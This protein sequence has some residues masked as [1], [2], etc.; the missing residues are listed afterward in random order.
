ML[1]T[2][3]AIAAEPARV[4][5]YIPRCLGVTF[6]RYS[7]SPPE[8]AETRRVDIPVCPPNS[9]ETFRHAEITDPKSVTHPRTVCKFTGRTDGLTDLG[10]RNRSPDRHQG[11]NRQVESRRDDCQ[12]MK[13]RDKNRG[14]KGRP[15]PLAGR[16]RHEHDAQGREKREPQVRGAIKRVPRL[17]VGFVEE[18][19]IA[20]T[21][22]A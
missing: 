19:E 9:I 6:L 20:K 13:E 8:R 4:Q 17:G 7:H 1:T 15:E 10:K 5:R 2:W 3:P 22:E 12:G 21:T 16:P 11:F 18:D 14:Q